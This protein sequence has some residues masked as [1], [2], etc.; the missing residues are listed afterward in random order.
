MSAMEQSDAIKEL[1]KRYDTGQAIFKQLFKLSDADLREKLISITDGNHKEILTNNS[2][3]IRTIRNSEPLKIEFY[4]YDCL[5]VDWTGVSIKPEH[6]C[7]YL[8]VKFNEHFR[9]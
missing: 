8:I 6:G 4:F 1:Q 5:I 3:C 9:L 2:D 7:E